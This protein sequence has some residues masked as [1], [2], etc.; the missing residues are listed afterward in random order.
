MKTGQVLMAGDT[1]T[2]I[3]IGVVTTAFLVL[4][5]AAAAFDICHHVTDEANKTR[6]LIKASRPGA[7]A[8]QGAKSP[9]D[10]A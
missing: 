6:A 3:R 2:A 9:V 7:S 10:P 4:T 1:S 8:Q 5:I